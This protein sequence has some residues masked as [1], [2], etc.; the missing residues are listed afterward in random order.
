MALEANIDVLGALRKYYQDL[1]VNND[2]DLR[3]S[4]AEPVLAFATQVNDAIY[5]LKMQSSRAKLLARI[6]SDRKSLVSPSSSLVPSLAE[7]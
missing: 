6:T 3:G 1:L 5:D 4:C 7:E 2:F